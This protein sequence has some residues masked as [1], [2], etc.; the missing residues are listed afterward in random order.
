MIPTSGYTTL[1]ELERPDAV[2]HV[3]NLVAGELEHL[4]EQLAR[5]RV[6][7]DQKHAS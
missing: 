2:D 3:V 4:P 1:Q 6:V 7:L 5:L